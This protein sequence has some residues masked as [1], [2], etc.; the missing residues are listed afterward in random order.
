MPLCAGLLAVGAALAFGTLRRTAT[1][2]HHLHVRV[3]GWLM[4]PPPVPRLAHRRAAG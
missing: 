4:E 2:P 1:A 3:H